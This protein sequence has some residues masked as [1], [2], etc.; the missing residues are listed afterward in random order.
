MTR[1]LRLSAGLC[2]ALLAGCAAG[3]NYKRPEVAMPVDWKLEAP[4]R[5]STP[6]DDA[7]KG[8]WWQ[9]FNDPVL[10]GLEEQA[11]ANSPTLAAA[12]ARVAQA[13]AALDAA[14]AARYPQIGATVRDTRARISALRPLT[15]NI[16]PNFTTT[17]NDF[18]VGGTV[19]YEVDLAG[20]IQRT[21]E[22]A[23][24]TAQQVSVDLENVRLFLTA[25]L[26][27]NYFNLRETDVELDVVTRSIDLQKASL[28][29]ATSRHDLGAASGLDVAQQQALLDS[30]LTQIDVLRRQRAQFEH[31]IAALSG[32]PPPLFKLDPV[33]LTAVTPP[34]VPLGVPSDVLERRPDVA[35]AERAM[36]AANAQV[37]VAEAAF[38]PSFN[39]GGLYGNES[40]KLTTLFSTPAFIWSLGGALVQPI[41]D[42]GRIRANSVAA[43]AGY[44]ITV[45][46]YRRVVLTAMQEVEDGITG[47]ASLERAY[48]QSQ[49][50]IAS[51]RKVLDVATAR[52][53]GGVATY[54]DVIT[55]QQL[56]L[57]NERQAAQLLG[58]RFATS[59]FLVKALGGGWEGLPKVGAK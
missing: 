30:T 40:N 10:N 8:P 51:S 59:V 19:S 16:A 53:E 28:D 54:L 26:A 24:A 1:L 6:S 13:R 44:D 49:A 32:V 9:R 55:A 12:N 18:V 58:Q 3:P 21:V 15:N 25:D 5:V 20:R 45:A 29:L 23:A 57:S 33:G 14:G 35:S 56:L 7:P 46:N 50:A 27:T 36:A 11:L 41:F 34:A 17:Q 37:G 48:N 22:G 52:Y 38:Y 4:W 43:K 47:L 42:G 2:V 39:L 31:A